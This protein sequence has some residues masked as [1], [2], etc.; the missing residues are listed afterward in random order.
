MLTSEVSFINARDFIL[1]VTV[2]MLTAN[3]IDRSVAY[4]RAKRLVFYDT[5]QKK[6]VIST[7]LLPDQKIIVLECLKMHY[8]QTK[9]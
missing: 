6:H 2:G 1:R 7:M 3:Q 8:E 5:S 9:T 4:L